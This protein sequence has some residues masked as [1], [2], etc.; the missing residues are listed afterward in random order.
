M[1]PVYETGVETVLPIHNNL[2]A[3]SRS[4]HCAVKS[5][6]VHFVSSSDT[7]NSSVFSVSDKCSSSGM[8]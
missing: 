8:I 5:V 3:P 2:T 4:K 1:S 6:C 7:A